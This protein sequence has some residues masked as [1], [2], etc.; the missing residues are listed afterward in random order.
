MS[1][2][3]K[4]DE[5]KE[6]KNKDENQE[7]QEQEEKKEE[8]NK[9]TEEEQDYKEKWLRAQADY[10][11]LKKSLSEKREE[12]RNRVEF[13]VLEEFIPVFDNFKK[14]Y[15]HKPEEA[16]DNQ[17]GNWA[18]GMEFILQQFDK[19]LNKF[20]VQTIDTDNK[21]F[22]PNLHE[23]VERRESEDYKE[24][25]IIEEIESG[26]KA[27]DKVLKAARVVVSKGDDST[28]E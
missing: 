28:E 8:Q 1:Q 10:Q 25:V 5:K 23:A 27:D 14:A 24:D 19:I 3:K 22:D 21:K 17:W 16:D 26:Y 15:K 11:N 6:E 4:Q 2:D 12:I 18:Q 20:G 7:T 13:Q 9:E